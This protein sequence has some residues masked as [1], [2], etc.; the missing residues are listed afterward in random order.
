MKARLGFSIATAIT[1]D[2]LLLDEVLGT[3]DQVFRTRSQA[4]VRE[5][6]GR[7]R[8]VVLVTHDLTYVTEF[9]SRAILLEK[10]R[11][12]HDGDPAETVEI[13]RRRARE[14][15]LLAEA[16]A[17]RFTTPPAPEPAAR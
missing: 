15:R 3:G 4:R 12:I 9:C 13:Y 10:G 17:E 11:I 8:V 16:D 1:P 6:I 2:I 14:S 5:L 7:A